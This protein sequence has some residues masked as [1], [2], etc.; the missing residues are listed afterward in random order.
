MV[1]KLIKTVWKRAKMV[2]LALAV[3]SLLAACG[4]DKEDNNISDNQ[5][6]QGVFRE[7][8]KMEQVLGVIEGDSNVAAIAC[9]DNIL[10]MLVN[11]Y[12]KG[13]HTVVLRAWDKAG[14]KLS[15]A[16]VYKIAP[17]EAGPDV[18]VMPLV[19]DGIDTE[20]N[21]SSVTRNAYD[22]RI[23]PQG[24]VLYTLNES[25]TGKN[26]ESVDRNI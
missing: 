25:G 8:E 23:T 21:T 26:G 1:E 19:A 2:V 12:P 14:N 13:G 5:V 6:K 3:S 15:E 20:V 10:Y 7:K 18:G 17:G 16:T 11:A 4:E 22:F 24:N 9:Y